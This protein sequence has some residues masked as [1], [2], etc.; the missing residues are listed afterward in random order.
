[1]RQ[2]QGQPW[3]WFQGLAQ[4][5]VPGGSINIISNFNFIKRIA[6]SNQIEI[7]IEGDRKILY[8]EL[9]LENKIYLQEFIES[10]ISL[11]EQV[12]GY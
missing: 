11:D 7:K 8:S 9:S 10:F 12:S 3:L 2:E 5:Q 4:V 6:Y 1:M